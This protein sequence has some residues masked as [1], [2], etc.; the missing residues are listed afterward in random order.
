MTY[1]IQ[2]YERIESQL[3][4]AGTALRA[5]RATVRDASGIGYRLVL[6]DK[7]RIAQEAIVVAFSLCRDGK[8]NL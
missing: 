7:L 2:Q 3:M 8:E 4:N 5:A 1:D 6:A